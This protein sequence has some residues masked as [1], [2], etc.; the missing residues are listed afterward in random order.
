[1]LYRTSGHSRIRAW[2]ELM[3]SKEDMLKCCRREGTPLLE[4]D[5]AI[6]V[7]QE[8]NPGEF[9]VM[10]ASMGGLMALYTGL[11]LP[12]I[13]GKVLAQSGAYV[14]DDY[15]FITSSLIE[16]GTKPDLKIW[17][18]VCVFENLLENN[19]MMRGKLQEFGYEVD[20]HEYPAG[21]NY[22]AWRD[23]LPGGLGTLFGW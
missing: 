23:D 11:R 1:M 15:E 10:G 22:S 16:D 6:F 18:D 12:H 5:R 19:R 14:L 8:E 17:M 13:F 4:D 3:G 21:H 9:G 7:W 20:F 2:G